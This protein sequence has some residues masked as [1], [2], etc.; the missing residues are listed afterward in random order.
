MPSKNTVLSVKTSFLDQMVKWLQ[1]KKLQC[2]TDFQP[3][4]QCLPKTRSHQLKQVFL[5]QIVKWLL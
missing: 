1:L 5:D 3:L 4:Q 2:K